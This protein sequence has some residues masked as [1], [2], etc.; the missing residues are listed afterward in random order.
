ML[1][2]TFP[3]NVVKILHATCFIL[4]QYIWNINFNGL[5]NF[6]RKIYFCHFLKNG[7]EKLYNFFSIDRTNWDLVIYLGW[8]KF[9]LTVFENIVNFDKIKAAKTLLHNSTKRSI[10]FRLNLRCMRYI[11]HRLRS[12]YKCWTSLSHFLDFLILSRIF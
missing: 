12:N 3:Y 4:F 10:R 7:L 8:T 11:D 9:V 5:Q 2:A 1:L 6:R